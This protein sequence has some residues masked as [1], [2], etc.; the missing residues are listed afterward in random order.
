[1]L[2]GLALAWGSFFVV[3]WNV[4]TVS[5]RQ[6][7]VPDHLLGRVNSAYRM[8]AWG[9]APLGALAGGALAAATSTGVAFT[10]AGAC[11][12][13]MVFVVWGIRGIAFPGRG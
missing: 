10:A 9:F 7:A 3:L 6:A 8:C 1:M 4:V 12:L 2:V 13:L 11:T 5:Y